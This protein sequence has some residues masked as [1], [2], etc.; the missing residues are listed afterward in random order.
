MPSHHLPLGPLKPVAQNRSA[1][2]PEGAS[3]WRTNLARGEVA[4]L[5]E[6]VET[7]FVA[8]VLAVMVQSDLE[9]HKKLNPDFG[10]N[11]FTTFAS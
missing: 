3:R 2:P 8:K 7:D 4:R 1:P 6:A 10:V 5:H 11:F 9:D